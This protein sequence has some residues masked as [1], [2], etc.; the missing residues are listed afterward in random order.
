MSLTEQRPP[1]CVANA[2]ISEAT[3]IDKLCKTVVEVH[4]GSAYNASISDGEGNDQR[5]ESVCSARRPASGGIYEE[6]KCG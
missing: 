4:G 2:R 3:S 1:S 5:G 6:F